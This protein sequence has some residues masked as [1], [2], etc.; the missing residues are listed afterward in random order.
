MIIDTSLV[1]SDQQ[2]VTVSAP[3]ANTI[4]LG[5]TG[6]PFGA[7][8]PLLR[9]IGRGER[10]DLAV[11]VSQAFAGLTSLQISV[12]TSPDNVTW[13]S[14]DSGAPIAAAS[15]N[16]GY[17]FRV[18]NLVQ[19]APARYLRLYYTVVGAAT[20]GAI[21]AAVV[22]SRQTNIASGAI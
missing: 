6:T 8:N 5:A 21:S 11:S 3:S 22:A 9:D 14:V 12:Q 16:T 17:M 20:A 2:L 1:F 13:T 10:L 18:P 4:D 15:L 7:A 19:N